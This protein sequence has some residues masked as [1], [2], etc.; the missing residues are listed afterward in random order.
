[1]E[2]QDTITL[3]PSVLITIARHAALQIEGVART[4]VIPVDV[5]RLLRGHPMGGGVVLVIK[6]NR[7]AVDMY[8][9]I[10]PGLSMHEVGVAV[11]QAI[12]RSIQELV[13]ME[14]TAVN[15]HIDDVD[16]PMT[17]TPSD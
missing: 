9:V 10:K 16:F 8:L 13:G 15:I 7:V 6:E 14:V 4:G 5:I 1:M 3:A 11:Q 2:P 17:D 12:K